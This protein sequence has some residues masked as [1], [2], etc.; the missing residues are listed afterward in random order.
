MDIE[1]AFEWNGRDSR[2]K[3]VKPFIAPRDD[4]VEWLRG[5]DDRGEIDVVID[6]LSPFFV[7]NFIL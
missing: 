5:I 6:E 4:N 1:R 7:V 2:V 3:G